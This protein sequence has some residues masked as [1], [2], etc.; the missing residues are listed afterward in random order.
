MA[1]PKRS[2]PKNPLGKIR[3]PYSVVPPHILK[4]YSHAFNSAAEFFR[5]LAQ[6]LALDIKRAKMEIRAKE[7]LNMCLFASS[8]LTIFLMLITFMFLDGFGM[9]NSFFVAIIIGLIIGFFI[10]MQQIM[11]PRLIAARIA[12]DVERNLLPSLQ[13][14]LIQL[15]AGVPL[16]NVLYSIS[17]MD[18]GE[19]S[20]E[21]KTIVKEISAGTD[22][23]KALEETAAANA[24]PLFRGIIWQL[25]NGMKSGANMGTLIKEGIRTI[26]EEQVI[27]I[28]KYGGQLNP[29]AMFYML[30]AVIVPALSMTFII[31][32]S[33]FIA[34]GETLT[35]AI[36]WTLYGMIL[37]MQIMFLGVI[38]S[39]RPNLLGD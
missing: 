25:V 32:L 13:N 5:P 36:F 38:K 8:I 14:M 4:Q 2:S 20:N 37:F 17:N 16:F 9:K 35:K 29:I 26:S 10:L 39:K 18:Y 22:Q 33:S 31:V 7:Y 15:N 6:R 24:S 11:Y 12:K 23:V 27:Q 30:A 21:F 34:I 3:I 28:Q 1:S 19:I